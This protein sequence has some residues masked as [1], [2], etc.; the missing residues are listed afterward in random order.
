MKC[1]NHSVPP[2]KVSEILKRVRVE[3]D[4]DGEAVC[5]PLPFVNMNHRVDVRVTDFQPSDLQGFV[6]PKKASKFDALS[7]N[8]DS[9]L[10]SGSDTM[11][12]LETEREWEWRFALQLED[13]TPNAEPRE[14]FWVAVDNQAA[15]CL[16]NLDASNLKHD[17]ENLEAL[18]QRMF[19][20]WGDLEEQKSA[21]EARPAQAM[22]VANEDQPPP[23]SS[24]NEAEPQMGKVTNRPF[25]CCVRQYGVK[26]RESDPSKADAGKGYRW[27]RMFG[28]YGTRIAGN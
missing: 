7:D 20:L 14:R 3:T 8:E 5:L 1:E 22:R 27:V 28:L 21:I 13:A 25:S 16:T 11:R 17:P 4:V 12:E 10:E 19:Y 15:Q 24:D 18:R 6:H 2:S 26:V 23:D 9:D